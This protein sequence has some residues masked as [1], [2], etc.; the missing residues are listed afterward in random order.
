MRRWLP[1]AL[2]LV[3]AISVVA[4][5]HAAGGG[6]YTPSRV[7]SPC[8]PRRWPPVSGLS[9]IENQLALSAIDGAACRLH[10][11]AAGLALALGSTGSLARFQAAHHIGDA[12]LLDA[13][14]LGAQRAFADAR[15]SGAIDASIATLLQAGAQAVPRTWLLQQARRALGG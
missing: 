4:A 15:R 14:R 13:A 11:S 7:A 6:S 3:L 12:Q 8:L 1:P 5:Y 2:A 9:A 10:T